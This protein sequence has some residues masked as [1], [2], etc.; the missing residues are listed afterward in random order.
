MNN[1]EAKKQ[2]REPLASPFEVAQIAISL[3]T[4]RGEAQPNLNSAVEFLREAAMRVQDEKRPRSYWASRWFEDW[5]EV[6]ADNPPQQP[7]LRPSTH[8]KEWAE[9][10]KQWRAFPG[11]DQITKPDG[12]SFSLM[13]IVKAVTRRRES[14]RNMAVIKELKKTGVLN[15]LGN[16][17]R[18]NGEGC[19]WMM[20][21]KIAPFAPR[22]RALYP[23]KKTARKKNK[24]GQF[25]APIQ[26]EQGRFKKRSKA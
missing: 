6:P 2:E 11:G 3:A 21:E 19:F 8:P 5:E 7:I 4:L 23:M 12:H 22:F 10:L 26:T 25:I 1:S 24:K 13:D 16:N 14:E 15:S 17:T 18:F 9:L 20:A